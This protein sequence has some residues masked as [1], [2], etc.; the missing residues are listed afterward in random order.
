MREDGGM[1]ME[2]RWDEPWTLRLAAALET[3]PSCFRASTDRLSR[4]DRIVAGV[5]LTGVIDHITQ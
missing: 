4:S 3:A 1:G 5:Q 2:D